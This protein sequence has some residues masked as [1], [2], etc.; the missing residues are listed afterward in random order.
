MSLSDSEHEAV[1]P[2]QVDGLDGAVI[3][4]RARP[5]ELHTG[6]APLGADVRLL[7]GR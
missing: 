6:P 1:E 3:P 7:P 5:T 2:S 4:R